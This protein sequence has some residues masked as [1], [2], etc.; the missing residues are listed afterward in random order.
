[1]QIRAIRTT[2]QAMGKK[3]PQTRK[4]HL[5]L[6]QIADSG[7][8]TGAFGHSQ[9]LEYAIRKDWIRSRED[10]MMWVEDAL[11]H[12]LI[13]LDGRA[14]LKSW[15]NT[16]GFNQ[17][18]WIELNRE[19][20][21]MRPSL[22]QRQASFETGLSL[23]ENAIV[24]FDLDLP[25]LEEEVFIQ[26]PVVWGRICNILDIPVKETVETLLLGAIRGWA[27]VAMRIIPLGQRD[28]YRFLADCAKLLEA[29]EWDWDDEAAK[30]L[31][32]LSP[33]LDIAQ[34]GHQNLHARSFRS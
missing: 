27:H 12:T 7:Y 14:C 24:S 30:P 15:R 1:M 3:K 4:W 33:G 10:L 11:R 23:W 31:E 18:K 20:T 17:R 16:L 13:P 5:R 22:E 25:S 32:S 9:G 2:N 21:A 6:L 19:V 29:G 28:S 26:W 34:M 8:P